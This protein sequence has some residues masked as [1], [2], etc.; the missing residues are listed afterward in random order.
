M[1]LSLKLTTPRHWHLTRQI[2]AILISPQVGCVWPIDLWE[3]EAGGRP[4]QENRQIQI[5]SLRPLEPSFNSDQLQ[6]NIPQSLQ[7][8]PILARWDRKEW[9]KIGKETHSIWYLKE[10]D[11][12]NASIWKVKTISTLLMII[13]GPQR[14]TGANVGEGSISSR[15]RR[16]GEREKRREEHQCKNNKEVERDLMPQY[17]KICNQQVCWIIHIEVFFRNSWAIP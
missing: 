8:T 17:L 15:G 7:G 2:G 11:A 14:G 5:R 3:I 13:S 9:V 16:T 6:S 4:A 10:K 12:P 1:K